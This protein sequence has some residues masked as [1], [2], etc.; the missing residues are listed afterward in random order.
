MT[1]AIMITPIKD[2]YGQYWEYV[3]K[4]VDSK[5][6]VYSK[7]VPHLL[8]TYFEA[9]TGKPIDFQKNY[10]GEWRGYRWRPKELSDRVESRKQLEA[11]M[12]LESHAV[13]S[14]DPAKDTSDAIDKMVLEQLIEIAKSK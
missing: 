11:L 13:V 1:T 3:E 6:W 4:N 12:E 8:D 14:P 10:E 7:E 9:N 2:A 5:G